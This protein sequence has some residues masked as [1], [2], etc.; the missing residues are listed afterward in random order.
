VLPR[1]VDSLQRMYYYL[2]ELRRTRSEVVPEAYLYDVLQTRSYS[3]AE[4]SH[5]RTV[6]LAARLA[7]LSG[8]SPSDAELRSSIALYNRIRSGLARLI[9]RRRAVPCGFPGAAALDVFTACQLM[10]PTEFLAVLDTLL[11]S[12]PQTAP[13]TRV[14]VAG[15][16]HDEPVLHTRIAMGG[17]QVV[18]DHHFRGE[19]LLG[20]P[21]DETLPPLRALSTHYQ[22]DVTSARTFPASVDGFVELVRS[23]RAQGVIFYYYAQEEALTWDHVEQRQALQAAGVPWLCLSMQPYPA[24]E[25]VDAE[26][27]AFLARISEG[28]P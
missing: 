24:S 20:P 19:L 14:V 4:Y 7:G 28:H 8:H 3:S 12:P 1:A 21:V 26:V 2:C 16:A 27:Q 25:A 6:E 22:H 5:A 23:A 13:G 17:G 9:E 18:G 10:P 15:S 11:A